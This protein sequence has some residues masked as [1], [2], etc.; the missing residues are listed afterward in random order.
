MTLRTTA[1]IAG[2]LG[3][4]MLIAGLLANNAR[5]DREVLTT[6]SLE[7]P[8][9]V[10]GP[11]IIALQG[12]DRISVD[13]KGGI[14]AHTARPAD[15]SGWLKQYSATYVTGYAGWD[16]LA[17]RMES[18]V[19]LE[20]PSPSPS[21]SPSG[22]PTSP[23]PV[24]TDAATTDQGDAAVSADYGSADDWRSSWRG[25]NR[26]SLAVG[27]IA[28]GEYLVVYAADGSNLKNVQFSAVR[29]INDGW[30][31]PLMWI[32]AMLAVLGAVAALSGL[33]DTRPVQARAEGWLRGRS[34]IAAGDSIRPGSRRE[35]RLAGS[36][37]PDV[38]LD[39]HEVFGRGAPSSLAVDEADGLNPPKPATKEGGVS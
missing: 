14:E 9:V 2:A 26:V 25:V 33:V 8:V 37:L 29:Q 4:L 17:T 12:L 6:A 1:I 34:R 7:T 16:A 20:S 30:I 3:L 38:L 18:R 22:A 39:D 19:V 10:V 11:E 36:S 15:A 5:P 21:P 13:A 35:R 31:D 23:S 32:G 27:A 28:P 24:P